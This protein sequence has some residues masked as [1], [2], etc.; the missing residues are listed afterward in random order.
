MKVKSFECPKS[1]RNNEKNNTWNIR[2]LVDE[3]CLVNESFVPAPQRTRVLLYCRLTDFW[4][5]H[6]KISENFFFGEANK[7][8]ISKLK[9]CKQ[10]DWDYVKLKN[11]G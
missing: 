7:A 11:N 9:Y 6:L 5:V 3:T 1:I 4:R 8:M 2:C 10:I